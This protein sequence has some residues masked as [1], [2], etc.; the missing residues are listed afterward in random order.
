MFVFLKKSDGVERTFCSLSTAQ[1]DPQSKD[2]TS[3]F[4]LGLCYDRRTNSLFFT[5]RDECT[6]W[7]VTIPTN[8][9]GFKI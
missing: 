4:P 2:M 8:P 5:D 1:I 3:M 9:K 6:L 7:Q